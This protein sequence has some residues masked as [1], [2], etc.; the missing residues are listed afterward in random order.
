MQTSL[1]KDKKS[2]DD[3]SVFTRLSRIGLEIF[4]ITIEDEIKWFSVGRI[5]LSQ[6]FGGTSRGTFPTIKEERVQK[7]GFDNLMYASLVSTQ[8]P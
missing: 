6:H 2:L 1:K 4:P 8:K 3:V 5:F 7:H